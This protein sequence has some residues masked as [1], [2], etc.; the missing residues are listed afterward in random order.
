VKGVCVGKTLAALL[1]DVIEG[2]VENTPASLEA[3]LASL[4]ENEKLRRMKNEKE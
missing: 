4:K 3:R 1:D 2:R